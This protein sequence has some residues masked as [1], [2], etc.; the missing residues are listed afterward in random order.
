MG[1]RDSGKDKSPVKP[2]KGKSLA[3]SKP[4]G[5]NEML[6]DVAEELSAS[7]ATG[8]P[9]PSQ[10][11]EGGAGGAAFG[12]S[13]SDTTAYCLAVALLEGRVEQR[14]KRRDKVTKDRDL[15]RAKAEELQKKNAELEAKQEMCF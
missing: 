12:A 5:L 14:T 9:Q 1:K 7:G 6:Q 11:N 2:I 15:A 10:N 3:N 4:D 13:A 8:S